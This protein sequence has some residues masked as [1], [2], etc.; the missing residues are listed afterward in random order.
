MHNIFVGYRLLYWV[1]WNFGYIFIR[2]KEEH[3]LIILLF[4]DL[5]SNQVTC[6]N[7]AKRTWISAKQA[8]TEHQG[9][10]VLKQELE[11]VTKCETPDGIWVGLRKTATVEGTY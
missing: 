8:C 10:L 3:R 4:S 6:M 9:S 2:T 7:K 5:Q 1:N 11:N